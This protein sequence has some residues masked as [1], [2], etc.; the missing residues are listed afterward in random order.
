MPAA[1]RAT[2]FRLSAQRTVLRQEIAR[3]SLGVP[4]ALLLYALLRAAGLL[5]LWA[6]ATAEHGGLS[7]WHI[8]TRL[9]AGWYAQIATRGYD[10]AIPVGLDGVPAPTNLAFLPLYPGLVAVVHLLM[11]VTAAELV[12]SWCAGL[13]AA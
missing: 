2:S 12:V 4:A 3:R 10:T 6:Y 9:D 7:L 5:T 11:P 13:A 8:L 1:L